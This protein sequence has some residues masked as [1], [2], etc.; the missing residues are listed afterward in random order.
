HVRNA[1]S[2][3]DQVADEDRLSILWMTPDAAAVLCITQ[4]AE[5]L[6][7]LGGASVNV[8]DDIERP[9]VELAVVPQRLSL[10]RNLGDL[11]FRLEH[12]QVT[13]SFPLKTA[14]RSLELA[15]LLTNHVCAKGAIRASL[16]PGFA[17]SLRQIENDCDGQHVIPAR[18]LDQR[19]ACFRLDVGGVDDGQQSA[20]QALRCEK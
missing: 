17:H 15:P 4:L 1:W 3:V 6:L 13:K 5:E 12:M 2:A 8:A 16:V 19:L 7:D 10:D 18:Q 14:Q 11:G 9:M 20:R